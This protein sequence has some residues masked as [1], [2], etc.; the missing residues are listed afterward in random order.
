MVTQTSLEG[1]LGMCFLPVVFNLSLPPPPLLF[2]F[3]LL[4]SRPGY[5][6]FSKKV[7]HKPGFEIRIWSWFANYI[8][9]ADYGLHKPHV[10]ISHVTVCNVIYIV[11]HSLLWEKLKLRAWRY[12]DSES[13]IYFTPS[14]ILSC[15]AL[16]KGFPD[17]AIC[18]CTKTSTMLSFMGLCNITNLIVPTHKYMMM[19]MILLIIHKV[20]S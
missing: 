18:I 9:W 7:F 12:H 19:M 16:T 14:L 15:L 17:S 1:K 20:L 2:F 3:L 6:Y 5:S 11:H 4:L 13:K 10:I 8:L